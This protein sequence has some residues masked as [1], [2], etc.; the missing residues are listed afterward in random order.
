VAAAAA[1][2]MLYVG[3]VHHPGVRGPLVRPSTVVWMSDTAASRRDD[4]DLR[5]SW[6]DAAMKTSKAVE[7]WHAAL[8]ETWKPWYKDNSRE[9]RYDT[10]HRWEAFGALY[11]DDSVTT[12]A[13][14]AR[15][16]LEADFAALF[17][18]DLQG[19]ELEAA[20]TAWQESHLSPAI[21]SA[22]WRRGSGPQLLRA[23]PCTYPTVRR[24]LWRRVNRHSSCEASSRNGRLG[25]WGIRSS[26]HSQSLVASSRSP[27]PTRSP[28][29][30]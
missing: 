8:G 15:Y 24:G 1:F 27:T 28:G 25:D 17:D 11:I 18:P 7:A 20:I 14:G 9:F 6:F 29:S 2:V 3:A 26:S 23:S 13:S 12:T 21:G 30:D 16:A 5:R 22:C 10:L 4:A 19:E